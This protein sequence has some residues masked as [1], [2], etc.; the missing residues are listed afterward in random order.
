METAQTVAPGRSKTNLSATRHEL[1]QAFVKL[2]IDRL[3]DD[4]RI[5][6]RMVGGEIRLRHV[7]DTCGSPETH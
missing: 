5:R 7:C 2:M 3:S 1:I 4:Q 6:Q